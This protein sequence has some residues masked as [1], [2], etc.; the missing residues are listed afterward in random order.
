MLQYISFVACKFTLFNFG[1]LR[2][3]VL[4]NVGFEGL[5][6]KEL[7]CTTLALSL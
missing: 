6:I 3:G 5:Y 2:D 7:Q 1:M 4:N